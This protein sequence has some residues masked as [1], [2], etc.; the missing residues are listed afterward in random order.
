MAN[1]WLPTEA[2]RLTRFVP[3][4]TAGAGLL[5]V[6]GGAVITSGWLAHELFIVRGGLDG[7]TVVLAAALCFLLSG[8]GLLLSGRAGLVA[9]VAQLA[10][11]V[12]LIGVAG[13][14]LASV[15]LSVDLGMDLAARD[16]WLD[17]GNP[18]P[19]RLAPFASAAF[20][21][22]GLSLLLLGRTTRRAGSAVV[23]LLAFVLVVLAIVA[24]ASNWLN[25]SG[26]Y[27]WRNIPAATVPTGLGLLLLAL[28]TWLR[29]HEPGEATTTRREEWHLTIVAAEILVVVALVAGLT[30]FAILQRTVVTAFGDALEDNLADRRR[31][32]DNLIRDA[33]QANG[34]VANRP[35][36]ARLIDRLNRD[37]A[38]ADAQRQLETSLN[39]LLPFNYR[40]LTYLDRE[41]RTLATIGPTD[42]PYPVLA[43]LYTVEG[44][45]LAWSERGFVLVQRLPILL[46]GAV[47]GGVLAERHM[48]PLT[49]AYHAVAHIGSTASSRVCAL[50]GGGA[51][52]FPSLQEPTN[53]IRTTPSTLLV[54]PMTLALAGQTGL[55]RYR[56]DE[57]R[58][59]I[60]AYGPIGTYGLGLILRIDAA[61]LYAPIRQELEI[62]APILLLLVV[63]GTLCLRS[64]ITPLARRLRELATIDGLTG[65]LN[66]RAFM[67]FA[68]AELAV[69]RRYGR[70]LSILMLDADH[71]KKVNDTHGHDAGDAVLRALSAT[72]RTALRDVD[73]LGRLGGEEFAVALP[74]TPRG[75][76][77]AVADRVRMAL[78]ALEVPTGAKVLTFTVSIGVASLSEPTDTIER[79]L[80]AADKALY[81]AKQAG[82]NRVVAALGAA[83]MPAP[84]E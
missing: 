84:A 32:F 8:V 67:R 10:C 37:P 25:I 19:G 46:D 45:S 34:L 77:I 80:T 56:D 23:E 11:A 41:G 81:A 66:R 12:L 22:S 6:L 4:P 60:N 65:T 70:Q 61:E 36:L 21:V 49:A 71:F 50:A 62:V 9:R 44:V 27:G 5:C 52:C 55:M 40:R 57:G 82:R 48:Q 38:D 15:L 72:C 2:H 26:L 7:A 63:V 28:G 31:S 75:A 54:S 74:E 42:S 29:A 13:A 83:A 64:Q 43:P 53:F 51:T 14:A 33:M 24:L 17:A 79:L 18:T 1:R 35:A 39:A 73:L 30:G 76:A 47:V 58:E 69:A 68:D 16:R 20:A 59:L 3:C 78:A